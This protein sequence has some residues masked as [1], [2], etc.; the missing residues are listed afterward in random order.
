MKDKVFKTI[1]IS[2]AFVGLMGLSLTFFENRKNINDTLKKDIEFQNQ[3]EFNV[4]LARELLPIKEQTGDILSMRQVNSKPNRL[5]LGSKLV[6]LDEALDDCINNIGNMKVTENQK[7]AKEKT[8][9]KLNKLKFDILSL[10]EK[11]KAE[12]FKFNGDKEIDAVYINIKNDLY[13]IDDFVGISE[14]I[15]N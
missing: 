11:V 10:S 2:L 12:S 3:N 14:Q 9:L 1:I 8:I 4:S 7:S 13:E 5:D 15:K 6:T